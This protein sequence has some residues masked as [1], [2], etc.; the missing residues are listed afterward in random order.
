[1]RGLRKILYK[2]I[3]ENEMFDVIEFF[4]DN[5]IVNLYYKSKSKF[6]IRI[7][8][9]YLHHFDYIGGNN[10]NEYNLDLKIGGIKYQVQIEEYYD[11]D[12]INDNV[13]NNINNN[14]M[15]HNS[16]NEYKKININDIKI[17][18]NKNRKIINFIKFGS[19]KNKYDE[20][21]EN[22]HCGIMI[23]DMEKKTSTIQSVNNYTN[24]I[25]CLSTGKNIF[26]IG[27]ILMQIMIIISLKNN[28][29]KI[30]LTDNSYL[31]CGKT[32]KIPLIY[33]RTLT[34]GKPFY[35]KYGFIPKYKQDLEA[36]NANILNF[37]KNKIIT[38]EQFIKYFYYRKFDE[39]IS[40]HKK[41][42]AYLNNDL[43]PRLKKENYVS[44][45]LASIINDETK[46]GCSILN[47]ILMKIYDD[48][49]YI[50]YDDKNFI[51]DLRQNKYFSK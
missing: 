15:T 44:D 36:Y 21:K 13:N 17:I 29:H 37:N 28:L 9:K 16:H 12:S 38:K 31:L 20:Y 1:M 50:K 7:I 3:P 42:L 8:N 51:L 25:K 10:T 34:Q 47:N 41:I 48:L 26:K 39:K 23:I 49:E 4:K 6:N 27:D 19:K 5:Q 43:I 24:C 33:L 22:D 30:H 40:E 18:E 2:Y 11:N 45:I 32:V 14:T 35:S 46:E